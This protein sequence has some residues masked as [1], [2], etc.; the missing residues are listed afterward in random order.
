MVYFFTSR[1]GHTIYVGKDKFENEELIKYGLPVDIW[2]HADE[3]SSAH[4]YLRL[5]ENETF[6]NFSQIALEDCLQM[7]KQGSIEGSKKEYINI[8][9]TPWSNLNKSQ[10]MEVGSVGYKDI[11]NKKLIKNIAKD[12]I[13]LKQVTKTK[14]EEYP[15]FAELRDQY[16]AERAKIQQQEFKKLEKIKQQEK[17]EQKQQAE[18][19]NYQTFFQSNQ[20]TTNKEQQDE[21]DFM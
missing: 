21:D 19:R 9:Y 13:I 7:T 18:Q 11:T 15:N 6:E 5:F 4:V 16:F 20:Y 3:Y 14:Q 2:F 17:I 10:G 12:P 1:D 8:V